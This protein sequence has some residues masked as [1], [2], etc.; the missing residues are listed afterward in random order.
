[1]TS[2]VGAKGLQASHVW[3][4]GVVEGH[5]PRSNSTPTDDEVCQ[6]LVALT[7]ARKSATL[8]SCRRFGSQ[9]LGRSLFVDWLKPFCD[10]LEINKAYFAQG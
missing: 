4:V 6:L 8:V 2:L 5:F 3:V 9:W 7:R 10:D 1:M